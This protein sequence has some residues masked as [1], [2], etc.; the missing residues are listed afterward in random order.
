[1]TT[2]PEIEDDEAH[3][4]AEALHDILEHAGKERAHFIIELLISEARRAGVHLPFKTTTAYVNTISP[5]DEERLPGDPQL[6]HRVRSLERWNA[7]AMVAQAANTTTEL[8]GHISSYASA[9]TLYSIGFNHFF[10]GPS[11]ENSG[12]LVYFQ[13][14]AAPG[15][16][17]RAFLEGRLTEEQ[18]RNYRR[19]VDGKGLTSYPHPWLMP[20][21]WQFP[22]VSMGLGP[23]TGI[24]Q[25][26]FMKYLNDRDLKNEADRKVWVFTGDGEM[27]EPESLGAISLAAR[28]NLDNL[29][30]VVNCNLQR[31]DGPSAWK[32]Q[33]YPRT[34]RRI[35]WCGLEC[36]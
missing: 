3:E 20:D 9:A 4:W 24:Y 8:G 30:F 34:G 21:F 29:I 6:E 16:Y 10:R 36:Y 22:T 26:R 32:W 15:V 14:H 33:N 27:D 18:L 31:L 17:A 23:I 19:D 5:I 11:E 35:S 25:A 1:M 2:R 28:E 13:G 7:L 12:D